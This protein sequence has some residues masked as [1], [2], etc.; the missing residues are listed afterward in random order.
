MAALWEMN[1]ETGSM[2]QIDI[3]PS[4]SVEKREVICSACVIRDSLQS[5]PLVCHSIRSVTVS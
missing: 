5:C 3:A 1:T 4:T 2:V